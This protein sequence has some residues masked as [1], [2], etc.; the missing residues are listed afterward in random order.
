M[1]TM[2]EHI[3]DGDVLGVALPEPQDIIIKIHWTMA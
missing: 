2:G 3:A 1:A